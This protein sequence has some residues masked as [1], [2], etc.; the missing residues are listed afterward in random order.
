MNKQ[1]LKKCILPRKTRIL[2]SMK[3]KGHEN[4]RGRNR[5]QG[6]QRNKGQEQWNR[7][8]EIKNKNTVLHILSKIFFESLI[9]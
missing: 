9:K 3:D 4:K 7:D 2:A 5:G 8:T 1:F 6:N